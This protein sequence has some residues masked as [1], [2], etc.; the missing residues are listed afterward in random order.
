MRL[1]AAAPLVHTYLTGNR[2]D[3]PW[4]VWSCFLAV[5][6]N[7]YWAGGNVIA[8]EVAGPPRMVPLVAPAPGQKL[9]AVVPTQETYPVQTFCQQLQIPAD[10][11]DE[12]DMP[13]RNFRNYHTVLVGSNR[14]DF[15]EKPERQVP[16]FFQP[17]VEF[18]AAGGHL[19]LLG[20]Y[21]GRNMEHLSRF[22]VKPVG[23]GGENFI[24][25]PDA[26]EALFLGSEEAIPK[27]NKLTFLG[28]VSVSRPHVIMLRRGDR[29]P[30][31]VTTAFGNGRVSIIMVEPY[32]QKDLWLMNVLLAW[33]QRGA[34]SR[35]SS[36]G[37]LGVV[38]NP[39]FK[40]I[41]VPSG[42][43]VTKEL[44]TVQG[45]F[46][47]EYR[48]LNPRSHAMGKELAG[49]LLDRASA[50]GLPAFD[51]ALLSE[52]RTLSIKNG[53]AAGVLNVTERISRQFQINP[54]ELLLDGLDQSS[55]NGETAAES[56]TVADAAIMGAQT[57]FA[58]QQLDI[59][60]KFLM[61]A[62]KNAKRARVT[63]LTRQIAEMKK[64]VGEAKPPGKK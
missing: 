52:A 41:P 9:L 22:D 54:L 20:T 60:D 35:L 2:S 59:A 34:P 61:L 13:N 4:F 28:R 51:Y 5:V 6:C 19:I 16:E 53:D 37:M 43:D 56:W 40:R 33:N 3:T 44:A 10:F 18:V 64:K 29:D 36:A 1:Q 58:N 48:Q 49:K 38:A 42:K 46:E 31:L 26:T 50:I 11:I 23:G 39:G 24:R 12:F 8:A 47:P 14:M 17:I 55:Q 62:G 27:D 32:Y 7:C 57:A 63:D 30:A 21:H 15:F 45:L 25:V